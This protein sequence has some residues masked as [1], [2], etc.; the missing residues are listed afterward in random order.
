MSG[1]SAF[2][3]QACILAFGDTQGV[4][5]GNNNAKGV[6]KRLCGSQEHNQRSS[7][8]AKFWPWQEVLALIQQPSMQ[9]FGPQ[10]WP[11]EHV[12][13]SSERPSKSLPGGPSTCFRTNQRPTCFWHKIWHQISARLFHSGR[14]SVELVIIPSHPPRMTE[15]RKT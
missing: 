13:H 4:G 2:L 15:E 11:Q 10:C 8:C 5:D 7:I 14:R 1:T 9:A 12:L 3:I 6:S